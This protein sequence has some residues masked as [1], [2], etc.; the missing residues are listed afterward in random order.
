MSEDDDRVEQLLDLFLYAPLGLALEARDLIPKL[1]DRGRG[2]VAL[3]RLAGKV[4]SERGRGEVGRL[5]DQ[6]AAIL[7]GIAGGE[8]TAPRSE[9]HPT[10]GTPAT[11]DTPSVDRLPIDDYDELTAPELLPFLSSLTDAELADVLAYEEV[12]RGR[13]TVINRI[14]QLQN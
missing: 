2:Q 3:T 4:A 9:G 8:P 7:G 1:A 11:G 6:V 5:F 14:R 10:G 13:A 12:N